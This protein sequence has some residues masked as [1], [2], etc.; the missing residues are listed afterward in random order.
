MML[1]VLA[2]AALALPAAAEDGVRLDVVAGGQALDSGGTRDAK[3]HEYGL[4]PKG[5]VVPLLR[6]TR[7]NADDPYLMTLEG[8]RVLEEAQRFTGVFEKTGLA[9]LTILYDQTPYHWSHG[10]LL[11]LTER[12][13]GVYTLD[14][15]ARAFLEEKASQTATAV[16]SLPPRVARL[17]DSTA[18]HTDLVAR[19]DARVFDGVVHVRPNWSVRAHAGLETRRGDRPISVGTYRRVGGADSLRFDRERFDV[20]GQEIP[21]TIDHRTVRAGVA[22]DWRGKRGFV[23]AG[24]DVSTFRDDLVG[25][26]WDNPFE[27]PGS[28]ASASDRGRYARGQLALPP[29]NEFGRAHVSGMFRI[30][31]RAQLSATIA[32]A[33]MRQD[34]EFLPFTLND[35]LWF[36]GPDGN[37]TTAAD[38][39]R[40]TD[41]SLLPASSLDAEVRTQR[42]DVRLTARPARKVSLEAT[43]RYYGYENRT[44]RID[45][46][47]YAAFGESYW[48]VGIGQKE[49]GK[50]VLYND[51][52]DYVQRRFGLNAG[53]SVLPPLHVSIGAERITWD[54]AG[55]QV[56]KT[57]EDVITGRLRGEGP[58]TLGWSAYFQNGN[59]EH[60]GDY[61]IGLEKSKLRM[62]DVWDRD[63]QQFGAEMDAE[64]TAG[65]VAALSASRTA[66]DYPGQVEGAAHAYGLQESFTNEAALWLNYRVSGRVSLHGGGGFDTSE[67]KNLTV[68]KTGFGHDNGATQYS[69]E[70]RWYRNQEDQTVWGGIGV[71]AAIVPDRL[72]AEASYNLNAYTGDAVTTNPE[73]PNINS[74]LAVDWSEFKT[75]THEF[76][77]ALDHR[78]TNGIGVGFRYLFRPF[79]LEDPAWNSLQPY[80]QGIVTEV[81][82]S[83]D[84]VRPEDVSRYLFMDNRYGETTSHV[85]AIVVTASLP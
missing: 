51:P 81:R 40:G 35:S 11:L 54:Y 37:L 69:S 58:W 29:D 57:D 66:D 10:S 82:A 71:K 42:A 32:A 28:V 70:N 60:S 27:A 8:T 38:N 30:G 2:I 80:M 59:R 9:R 45:F 63:R 48:R 5:A 61:E 72:T 36:P 1:A 53:W 16:D 24:L 19:R 23:E 21:E 64:L 14:P 33:R 73:T 25:L 84:D 77:V 20:R 47:G 13:P 39:I 6:L 76:R 3:F 41:A 15:S 26:Q 44:D 18:H 79:R 17:L 74:A 56:D 78:L 62:F 85:A 65:L 43:A 12:Q 50:D 7:N 68:T 52:S 83:A 49:D 67:W 4:V 46:P 22:T 34:D 75:T 31:T 55:R